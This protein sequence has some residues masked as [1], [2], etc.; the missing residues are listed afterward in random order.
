MFSQKIREVK[1]SNIKEGKFSLMSGSG[2][3]VFNFK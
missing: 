1:E 2:S 3:S